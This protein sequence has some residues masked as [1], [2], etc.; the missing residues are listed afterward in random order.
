MDISFKSLF[1]EILAKA[2]PPVLPLIGVVLAAMHNPGYQNIRMAAK[3]AHQQFGR[4]ESGIIRLRT[5][6]S[7]LMLTH[8]IRVH[9]NVRNI[10]GIE[11]A[12]K[13]DYGIG[14]QSGNQHAVNI[15]FI[16]KS[17]HNCI[18]GMVVVLVK[19]K[20]GNIDIVKFGLGSGFVYP[21]GN[22]FPIFSRFKRR[23]NGKEM[24]LL[25]RS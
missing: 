16:K 4:N 9:I 7:K 3:L 24:V 10:P 22:G 8:N 1:G 25:F 5:E 14:E 18:K 23:S 20:F 11:F 13:T 17:T 19:E 21:F 6:I 15:F 12:R 2:F